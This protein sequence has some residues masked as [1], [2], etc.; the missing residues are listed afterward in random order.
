[1]RDTT[2]IAVTSRSFSRHA[3]LR[4]ELQQRYS[5]VLFNDDG[6][7]L[8][9]DNLISFAKGRY[10]LITA[11]ERIDD[12]ILTALPDL[13]VI[14]KYGVGVDMLDLPAMIKHN[15]RLGWTGGVN[16]RSVAELAIAFM[17]SMLRQIPLCN[18]EIKRGEWINRKGRCLSGRTVGI[19][20]CGHVGKDLA[21]L[22]KAFGCHVLAHDIRDFPEF[23]S[24]YAIEAVPLEQLLMRSDIV[25]MH[26]PLNNSTRN[27]LSAEMLSLMPRSAILINTARGGL[28][29]EQAL[30]TML[31][32]K[33]LAAAAFDV[34]NDEPPSDMVLLKLPEFYC[35]PHIGGSSEEAILAMGRAAIDGLA[36]NRLPS[37]CFP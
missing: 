23:Y 37:A 16:R 14:S 28:V 25:T 34:F 26:L 17:I 2:P 20:G 29:D 6:I 21:V 4:N 18:S 9:G 19:I 27:I 7:T 22:L 12:N 3:T 8:A 11:L 5:N 35:T 36:D 10:K 33:Q 32:R 30:K 24:R 31:I 1:M 15:V 13:E